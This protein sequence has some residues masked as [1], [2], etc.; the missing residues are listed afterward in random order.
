MLLA[1]LHL[2]LTLSLPD[3]TA[4]DS[5]RVLPDLAILE[6]LLGESGGD[7]LAD[8]L[9]WRSEHPL[10]LNRA[11]V[12]RLLAIPGMCEEDAEAITSYRKQ[13]RGFHSVAQLETIPGGSARLYRLLSP[14]VS[15]REAGRPLLTLRSRALFR[16]RTGSSGAPRPRGSGSRSVR[17]RDWN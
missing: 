10:D 1:L 7:E 6:E 9:D 2:A 4:L 5:S 17:R 13:N 16:R 3:S 15:L 8:E 11:S 14:Y 12:H